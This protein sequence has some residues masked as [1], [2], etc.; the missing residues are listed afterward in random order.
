MCDR[1]TKSRC[2]FA[3]VALALVGCRSPTAITVAVDTDVDCPTVVNYGTTI[4]VGP[5]TPEIEQ[6]AAAATTTECVANGAIAKL[7]TVVVVPTGEKDDTI[8]IRVVTGVDGPEQTC[9]APDYHGCIVARRTLRY[10]PHEELKVNVTM[11]GV[12]K[13]V[14]CSPDRTCAR[15]TCVPAVLDSSRCTGAGCGE[16]ALN[17]SASGDDA[18]VS[19]GDGGGLT[20]APQ[21]IA[22]GS[23]H[24]CAITND[25]RVQCWGINKDGELGRGTIT[26][27][28]SAVADYVQRLSNVSRIAAGEY[29]TCALSGGNVFCWGYNFSEDVVPGTDNPKPEPTAMGGMPPDISAMALG[30]YHGCVVSHGE[31]WCWGMNQP[32]NAGAK[33]VGILGQQANLDSSV[34]PLKVPGVSGAVAIDAGGYHTCVLVPLSGAPNGPYGVQC[35]GLGDDGQLGDGQSMSGPSARTVPGLKAWG[36]SL[37]GYH[38]CAINDERKVVCWGQGQKLQLGTA[39]MTNSPVPQLASLPDRDPVKTITSGTA[40]SC[41]ILESGS[42]VC[43]GDNSHQQLD[44]PGTLSAPGAVTTSGILR[45]GLG[46]VHTCARRASD[47]VCWGDNTDGQ[48]GQTALVGSQSVGPAPVTSFTSF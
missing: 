45:L 28:P 41:A 20:S 8:S 1:S 36:L 31:V 46:D 9:K 44:R 11:R 4:T 3:V 40:H 25:S 2:L 14:V 48:S 10:I 34:V 12:C 5:P 23:Y 33:P 6:R 24:T 39:S 21:D 19:Q 42:T 35:W 13:N 47:I 27:T 15:G 7:G 29:H 22:A 18:G 32:P 26:I 37:G 43:W 38:S 17:S 16:E 30:S